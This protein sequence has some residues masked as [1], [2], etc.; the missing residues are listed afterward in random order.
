MQLCFYLQLKFQLSS[1]FTDTYRA[2]NTTKFF[3]M[4]DAVTK[5]EN[6][7]QNDPFVSLGRIM[8]ANG[9]L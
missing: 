3:I 5:P 9:I 1:A 2:N 6:Q 4:T 7:I 8:L